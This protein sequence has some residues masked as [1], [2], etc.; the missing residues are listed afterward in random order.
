MHLV[1]CHGL[2]SR[3]WVSRGPEAL[4]GREV[5]DRLYPG[6]V[7]G[8]LSFFFFF[9]P[10]HFTSAK[11]IKKTN[12]SDNFQNLESGVPKCLDVGH[13]FTHPSL[14]QKR[15]KLS[16]ISFKIEYEPGYH[17]NIIQYCLML[18]GD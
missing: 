10:F 5:R 15:P 3:C 1:Y 11:I 17:L 4:R 14:P 12:I 18:A 16:P 2:A 8:T 9:L 7:T 6:P 13:F